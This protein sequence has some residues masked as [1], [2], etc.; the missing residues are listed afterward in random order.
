MTKLIPV[1]QKQDTRFRID[2]KG[3]RDGESEDTKH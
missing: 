1:N 2:W 3:A